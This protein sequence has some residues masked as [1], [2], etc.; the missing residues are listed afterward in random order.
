MNFITTGTCFTNKPLK[1]DYYEKEFFT[2]IPQN[3]NLRKA[4]EGMQ[5]INPK[6]KIQRDQK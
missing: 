5:E 2:N 4:Y 3:K 1:Y 6:Q